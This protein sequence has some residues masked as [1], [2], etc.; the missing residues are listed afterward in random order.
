MSINASTVN[1]AGSLAA[2]VLILGC[3]WTVAQTSSAAGLQTPDEPTVL[4]DVPGFR[5]L[6][7]ELDE[8]LFDREERAREFLTEQCMRDLGLPYT[9]VASIRVPAGSAATSNS[10]TN[11]NDTFVAGLDAKEREDYFV[12]L[13]GVKDP[14]SP[15]LQTDLAGQGCA[16]RSFEQVPSVYAL[17]ST[18]GE[19]IEALRTAV[20]ASPEVAEADRAWQTCAGR[21]LTDLDPQSPSDLAAQLDATDVPLDLS[22]EVLEECDRQRDS[23]VQQVRARLEQDFVTEHRDALVRHTQQVQERH[24]WIDEVLGDT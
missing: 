12:A 21:A 11:P 7:W 23:V 14:F 20:D 17:A 16:G 22:L 6:G 8:E 19:E 10:F 24:A 3:V 5:L 13:Y 4:E 15:V 2:S 9:P 1:L 18:L